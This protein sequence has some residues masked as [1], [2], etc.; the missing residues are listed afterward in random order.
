MAEIASLESFQ[1]LYANLSTL[2]EQQQFLNLD[3]LGAELDAHA[4]YFR[5]LLDRKAKNGASRQSLSTGKL[6]LATHCSYCP[7]V[8]LIV[9]SRKAHSSGN[10]IRDQQ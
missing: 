1:A 8:E 9:A 10:R 2:P 4:Q 5:A 3:R 7:A 6:S